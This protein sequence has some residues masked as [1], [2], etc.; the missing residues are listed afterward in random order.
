MCIN[1][2]ICIF[3]DPL[4]RLR[5]SSMFGLGARGSRLGQANGHPNRVLGDTIPV[6]GV[7][8]I[9][10]ILKKSLDFTTNHRDMGG[11]WSQQ[12]I[13]QHVVRNLAFWVDSPIKS[14][15]YSHDNSQL[16]L[17]KDFWQT[18]LAI[19]GVQLCISRKFAGSSY[20]QKTA[21]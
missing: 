12:Y 17:F 8:R 18:N 9:R 19:D 21:W 11:I 2:Y 15:F 16:S 6:S 14:E 4:K 13:Q 1:I 10:I 3:H 5:D 7:A 20:A